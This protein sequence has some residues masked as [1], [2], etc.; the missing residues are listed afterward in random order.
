MRFWLDVHMRVSVQQRRNEQE[1]LLNGAK[2]AIRTARFVRNE[3]DLAWVVMHPA[4]VV[5]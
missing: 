1:G 3:Q 5:S 4:Q 2:R